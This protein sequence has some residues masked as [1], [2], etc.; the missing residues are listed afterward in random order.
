[1]KTKRSSWIYFSVFL[2]LTILLLI[3]CKKDDL[4]VPILTTTDI[5]SINQISAISGGEITSEGSSNVTSRGVCWSTSIEPSITD[6]KTNDGTG[7][8]SFTSSITGLSPNT[9][10]F[11][12]AF[13]TNSS[14]TGYGIAKSF[15]T[16]QATIPVITTAPV[17]SITQTTATSGGAITTDGAASI[18]ARGVCWST[19]QNP[20]IADNTTSDGTGLGDFVSN[21]TGLLGNTTYYLK[22]YATNSVGTAYGSQVSFT[23]SPLMPT[24]TTLSVSS[25]TAISCN[26]NGT[27]GSDGGAPVT[28]FGVCF[29]TSQNPTTADSKTIDGSGLGSFISYITGLQ[30][31]T[32]YY[33]R[34]YATNSVE[35]QYGTELTVKT[36]ETITDIDGNVYNIA[37]IDG[38]EP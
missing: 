6:N 16:E 24:I 31:N 4:Q 12:R 32:T 7:I 8:G 23:T 28:A 36:L 22:A 2:G 14:G 9:I 25:I 21:I 13:A 26:T 20:T 37:S 27:I 38:G 1:M 15:S 29:G 30:T 3:S 33:V 34:A 10:Y 35:T 18:T 5:T 17:S 19:S 11:V